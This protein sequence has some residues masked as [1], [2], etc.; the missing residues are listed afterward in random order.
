M[1][2]AD[3]FFTCLEAGWRRRYLVLIPIVAMPPLAFV[4]G[5]FAPKSFEA[6]TTILVQETAK[7]N[8]FLTDLAI[9]P[10]L[11]ERMPALNALVHSSH[12]LEQVLRDVHQFDDTI[13][14]SE[15][16]Q[17]VGALSSAISVDL[18]GTDLVTFKIKGPK[19]KGLALILTALSNRFLERMLAPERSAIT[20]SQI[21]LNKELAERG[22]RLKVAQSTLSSFRMKHAGRLPTLESSN[23]TRLTDLQAKLS[24]NRMELAAAKAE[25]GDLKERLIETNPMIGQIEEDILKDTRELGELRTRYTEEHS[26]VQGQLRVLKRLQDER[27]RLVKASQAINNQDLSALWNMAAGAMMKDGQTAPALL[28]SQMGKLQESSGKRARLETETGELEREVATLEKAMAESGPV[29][30]NEKQLE[31][32]I[33]FAQDSYDAIAKRFDNAEITGALG[34]FEA[35]ERVKI[36]D[37]PVDP[38]SPTT[39]GRLLFCICGLFGGIIMGAALATIAEILDPRMRRIV[40]FERAAGIA[41]I[42]RYSA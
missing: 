4:A 12:I 22:V 38:L 28:V 13:N 8:P 7:I 41:V 31:D 29:A 21:F 18:M 19:G 27:E 42:A 16:E 32:N 11:K 39:P 35:P 9:G 26:A 3:L 20:D 15:R 37:A 33:K 17:R 36:I 10:N 30:Q 25:L 14:Q 5:G 23:V 34:K 6:K 40:D 24:D 1:N 2:I